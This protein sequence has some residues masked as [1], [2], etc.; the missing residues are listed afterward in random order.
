M[1]SADLRA[2][3]GAGAPAAGRLTLTAFEPMMYVAYS[4]YLFAADVILLLHFAFVGFVVLGLAFIWLG[5][6][7]G[8]RSARNATFRVCHLLAMGFVLCESL[9]GVIRPLTEWEN[10][11]RVKG[12]AQPYDASFM[13]EWIGRIMFYDLSEGTFVLIY[14]VVFAL[15]LVALRVVPPDFARKRRHP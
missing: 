12:G 7:A 8:W 2:I 5:Y 15:I 3:G 14:A 11:L 9:A 10:A 1:A 13:Q 6:A 4:G